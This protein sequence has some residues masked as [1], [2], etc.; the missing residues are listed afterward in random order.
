[1]VWHI[2]KKDWKLMWRSAA[3]VVALQLAYA[4]IQLKGEFG[5][6][7]PVLDEFHLMLMYLWLIA[8]A[9]WVVMLV[10]QDAVPGT[11]Q[12]WLTRPIRRTDVLVA[13]VLFAALVV[14]G[15][16][17]AGDLL[18]GLGSGFPLGQSLRAAMVRAAIGFIAITIPALVIG[19]LTQSIAEA[20]ILSA[21]FGFG[22]FVC[23]LM[24]VALGGGYE[25]QFDPTNASGV[26]WIPNLLRFLMVLV[27]G[28]IVMLAQYRTRK[29]FRGR[30]MMAAILL[31]LL[32]SQ[33]IPWKPVFA[34]EERFSTQPGA[35]KEIAL[36]WQPH[37]VQAENPISADRFEFGM[38]V[39]N[40]NPNDDVRLLL[41]VSVTGLPT[42]SVLRVDNAQ[43]VLTDAGGK[44][45]YAVDG[46][47]I[48]I[49]REGSQSAPVAY[50]QAAKIPVQVY[51][52]NKDRSVRVDT[53]YSMTLFKLNAS[54]S[55]TVGGNRLITNWG[56]CESK[57]NVAA[58]E[59]EVRCMQMGKGPTSA[60][61]FLED[62]RDG[63]RN[64]PINSSNPNYS[65][66]IDRPIPD[67]VS[68]FRLVLPF[69]DPAG[70]VKYAV[71]ESKMDGAQIVIR[72]YEPADH[73]TRAVTSPS[74]M[75]K[76]LAVH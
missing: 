53:T 11:R 51:Q 55:M 47:S 76:D 15:S 59:V 4:F 29:T 32:C 56:R 42:D 1:M 24:A 62:P 6:G 17:I 67:A 43:M 74:I 10:H 7:N 26:G 3:A 41:P 48:G 37:T 52:D 46:G 30:I 73:F 61:V 72:V 21:V 19:T 58:T 31:L 22:I 57:I 9:I 45:L 68:H 44:R 16:T 71:D 18:Q 13:K 23:T 75:L 38:Q 49:R 36:A 63:S 12:D 65:S 20:M 8:G 69:R 40:H 28:A 66:Y 14:Q 2:F 25:H 54:Y 5:R 27:G 60:T 64:R 70:Q 39:G 34:L 50:D 33:A 35:A